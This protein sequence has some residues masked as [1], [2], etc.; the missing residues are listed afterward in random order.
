M[1]KVPIDYSNTIIYKLV[2]IEDLND[3]NIYIGHTTNMTQRKYGH[4]KRCCNIKNECYNLKVYKYIRENGGWNNWIMILIEKY[5]CDNVYE[6]IARERYWKKELKATLN[7]QEPGRTDQ[8]YRQDNKE[9]NY[10][11]SIEYYNKN[12]EI[13]C[14]NRK[15]KIICECGAVIRKDGVIRHYK[16]NKHIKK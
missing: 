10:K 13:I 14:E 3:D 6:A 16:S 15:E 2:N 1:P 7:T 12:K 4:R 11:Q 9:K 8:Q 5:P